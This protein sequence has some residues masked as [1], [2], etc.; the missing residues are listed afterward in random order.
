MED[1]IEFTTRYSRLSKKCVGGKITLP[2][3]IIYSSTWKQHFDQAME[4]A[5]KE[6]LIC[7]LM[8]K[9]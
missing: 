7:D 8:P 2:G 1:I 3:E 5:K 6:K 9:E 4:I